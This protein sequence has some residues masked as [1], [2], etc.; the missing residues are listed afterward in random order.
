MASDPE[1]YM[2]T[3]YSF[4]HLAPLSHAC[5]WAKVYSHVRCIMALTKLGCV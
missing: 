5:Y 4:C 1:A 3:F 2:E